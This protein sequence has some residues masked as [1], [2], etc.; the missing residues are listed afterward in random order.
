MHIKNLAKL[1]LSFAVFSLILLLDSS[2]A[3]A[4]LFRRA[5]TLGHFT[6]QP[7]AVTGTEVPGSSAMSVPTR[8]S[9]VEEYRPRSYTG[10]SDT[11]MRTY[12]TKYRHVYRPIPDGPT[13][14]GSNGQTLILAKYIGTHVRSPKEKRLGDFQDLN[15]GSVAQEL[16]ESTADVEMWK[17]PFL[18]G[19]LR[20]VPYIP[21]NGSAQTD[22][23]PSVELLKKELTQRN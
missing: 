10:H 11:G 8:I 18:D 9:G 20:W 22:S 15:Y 5:R 16:V 14:K 3:P 12:R 7:A 19:T 23:N 4:Q 6:Q 2:E 13:K 17:E 21:K 1:S